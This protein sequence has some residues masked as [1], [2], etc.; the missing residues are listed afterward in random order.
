MYHFDSKSFI[1]FMDEFEFESDNS[2]QISF[3]KENLL[4]G[5]E[6]RFENSC[7]TLIMSVKNK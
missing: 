2:I 4:N 7:K 1:Y 6:L 3:F 5:T